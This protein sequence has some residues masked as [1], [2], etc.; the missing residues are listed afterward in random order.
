MK[1]TMQRYGI[2]WNLQVVDVEKVLKIRLCCVQK[3]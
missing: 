3:W 2:F 1:N